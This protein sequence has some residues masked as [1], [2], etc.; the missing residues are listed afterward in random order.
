[1]RE[2]STTATINGPLE[3][4][5]G[6]LCRQRWVSPLTAALMVVGLVSRL[7]PLTEPHGRL[8]RQFMTEDGYL[9]QGI[10][11]NIA[12]GHGL[13]VSDG[14][15][16]TNGTQPL[17]AFLF[18]ALHYLAGADKILGI[19]YVEAFSAVVSLAAAWFFYALARKLLRGHPDGRPLAMLVA[20]LWFAS[21][22][23]VKHSMNGLETGLY[24][25]VSLATLDL[26][27]GFIEDNPNQFSPRQMVALGAMF[28]LCFLIRNDAAFLIAAALVARI[29][30][31]WPKSARLWR[32]R[33]VE[34]AIPGLI[35]LGIAMPWLVYNY[36]LFG[37]I[38]PI[39]G[40]AEALDVKR[41]ENLIYLPAKLLEFVTVVVPIPSLLETRTL[42][43]VLA[44]AVIAAALVLAGKTLW[45]SS[46]AAPFVLLTYGIFGI[47]L[48][49][50]YG[51]YFGVP[52]FLSRYFSVLSPALALVGITAAYR[53]LMLMRN[54]VRQMVVLP[55]AC[56][57]GLFVVALNGV[58]YRNGMWHQH[59]QVVDWVE[60]HVP[61][62]TWVG[63]VQTGTLGYFHDRTINLDGKVNPEAL[64]ARLTEGGVIPYVVRS[65]IEYL[66]DWVG[67]A[68]WAQIKE[69]GFNQKFK[70]I[71]NDKNAN[72]AVF[73]RVGS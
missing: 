25:L 52:Y 18:A 42:M 40:I 30:L 36:R 16:Q 46:T 4:Q 64:R 59:F 48:I 23:I 65:K 67:L 7:L 12:L 11:R 22:L 28:G 72:L 49:L 45:S 58:L 56:L 32:Y 15:I 29:V 66:A 8:L 21:P 73:Q 71:V 44:V 6:F 37:S 33:I 53:L 26:F 20:S 35:S 51:I 14:T 63:A 38:M 57:I 9:M 69:D 43:I 24:L 54:D 17:A 47:L 34:A 13:T 10:A 55:I 68:T 27:A 41:G 61:P 62:Q 3:P 5:E 1:M 70:L 2:S 19:A 39:S 60:A 50:F 31:L